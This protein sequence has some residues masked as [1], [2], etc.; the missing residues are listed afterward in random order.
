MTDD[1]GPTA[2]VASTSTGETEEIPFYRPGSSDS[3]SDEDAQRRETTATAD[4]RSTPAAR[5]TKG[6]GKTSRRL[7]ACDLCPRSFAKS[8]DL[9]SHKRTHTGEKPYKCDLC[10]E[11]FAQ[12]SALTRHKRTQH[13]F[14]NMPDFED[15][16]AAAF[17]PPNVGS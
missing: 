8:R 17:S 2:A 11:S 3:E 6:K 14:A 9:T 4:R 13:P 10:P 7:F 16:R 15:S 5:S 12:S 1:T